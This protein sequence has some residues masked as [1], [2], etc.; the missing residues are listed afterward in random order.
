MDVAVIIPARN[1]AAHIARAIH[2]AAT[3]SLPPREIIVVDDASSDDTGAV[4]EEL[5]LP[6]VR[7]LRRSAPG[8]GGYAARNAGVR[9]ATSR[10]VAFLD[11]DD[12][13]SSDHLQAIARAT[14]ANPA[15]Q[16]LS[17]AWVIVGPAGSRRINR[18]ARRYGAEGTRVLELSTFL[19]RWSNGR[20]PMW[21]SAVCAE[22]N[23]LEAIGGF[24][25]ERCTRG[26]D[27]DTWLRLVLTSRR[28]TIVPG[29]TAIYHRDIGTSVTRRRPPQISH[30]TSATVT[31]AL[32][33]ERSPRI[34]FLLKRL[35]NY[36]KKDPL[37][38]RARAQGIGFG[39]LRQLY[40]CASPGFGLL[41]LALAVLPG[42]VRARV[43]TL[44][45]RAVRLRR[46][47]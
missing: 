36:H 23:L 19:W 27:V 18:Y 35:G 13:W 9:A 31:R 7:F 43:L 4:V 29:A 24:P 16:V 3:Q 15:V 33:L 2:S 14:E 17:T 20:A 5:R 8:P 10:W 22:R 34:R 38:K 30:C 21:T 25:E 45:D 40:L 26:G 28:V 37:R 46:Q 32:E 39:D 42:A 47:R 6:S 1:A 11:A 41:M 12:E 44:R